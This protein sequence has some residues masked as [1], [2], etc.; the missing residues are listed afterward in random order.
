MECGIHG[1][2]SHDADT[3]VLRS[4]LLFRKRNGELLVAW[5]RCTD[6]TGLQPAGS[7]GAETHSDLTPT[8][9]NQQRPFLIRVG[10]PESDDDAFRG[11]GF[12]L[13][14]RRRSCT[15]DSAKNV[16]GWLL[17]PT[18][19]AALLS[20]TALGWDSICPA[21]KAKPLDGSM[22]QCRCWLPFH[23]SPSCRSSSGV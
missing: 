22:G 6:G 9:G 19:P 21:P 8:Q 13:E 11:G 4:Q 5:S 20:P 7:W 17:R 18:T 12:S 3:G 16:V 23:L 10:E 15:K 1:A 14:D 2:G